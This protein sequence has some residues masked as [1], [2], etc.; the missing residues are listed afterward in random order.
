MNDRLSLWRRANARKVSLQTL[1][2]DQFTLS[3]QLIKKMILLYQIL[4]GISPSLSRRLDFRNVSFRNSLRWSI[5]III[6]VDEIKFFSLCMFSKRCCVRLIRLR[7]VDLSYNSVLRPTYSRGLLK[8]DAIA[9]NDLSLKFLKCAQSVRRTFS[10]DYWKKI[11]RT[12][13]FRSSL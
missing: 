11:K 13:D 7:A 4:F 12:Y 8:W 10:V 5:C 6:S 9:D 1:Y 2:G 3:T